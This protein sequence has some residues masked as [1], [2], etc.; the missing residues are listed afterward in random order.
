MAAIAIPLKSLPIFQRYVFIIIVGGLPEGKKKTNQVS[1]GIKLRKIL[2]VSAMA[3][4]NKA[5]I[6]V[7]S[8]P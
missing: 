4:N 8:M 6:E 2:V 1:S 5:M 7:R 3:Q